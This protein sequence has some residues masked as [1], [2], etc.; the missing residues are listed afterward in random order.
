MDDLN[1]NQLI[2]LVLLVSFVTSVVTGI[3]TV[4]LVGESP[5]PFTQTIQRVIEQINPLSQNNQ[6]NNNQQANPL[7]AVNPSYDSGDE[8]IVK[9]VK[10]VSSSVVSVVAT[11]DM[12]IIEQYYINP[13]KDDPFW[14]MLPEG[15]LPDIQIPQYRQK[16][17]EEKKVSSG[18]GFFISK[19]GLLLT[20]KHVV[21][22]TSASYSIVTNDGRKLNAKVLAR[23]PL[24]DLAVLKVEGDNFNPIP[25]GDSDKL[26]VGQTVIAI[27][28][29]LGEFNNTVSKGII[30]G[31]NRTVSA[32]SPSGVEELTNLIQ[33]D[34]A[35]NHGNSGGP[36]LD[37]SGHV[38]GI[39]V[40]IAESA[41]N[42]G[43]ALPINIAKRDISD[44]KEFGTIKY[45]YIGIKYKT[46]EKGVEITEVILNSPAFKAGLKTGD[47]IVQINGKDIKD[48]SGLANIL[49]MLRVGDKI[50]V[51]V[52]R[53]GNYE[54]NFEIILEERPQNI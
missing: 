6:A 40:A 38:I 25:L 7:S 52:L 27:G 41:Q 4:S 33:T 13:F 49:S 37:L 46:A 50:Q 36:L 51:K 3:V 30:S 8:S 32:A 35:I 43:F 11:K 1:K 9:L 16:G 22:D 21:E 29:A 48:K 31:L 14:N 54:M 39:N 17:T 34:A 42:I 10:S 28:N 20:N 47:V 53:N 24:Q 44:A 12:P 45:P 5:A 18:T 23:D 2:M 15:F 26:N 19:D